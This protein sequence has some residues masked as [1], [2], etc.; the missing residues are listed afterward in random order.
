MVEV[1]ILHHLNIL[2]PRGNAFGNVQKAGRAVQ[3]WKSV[4]QICHHF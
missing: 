2:R 4:I 3:S 1:I